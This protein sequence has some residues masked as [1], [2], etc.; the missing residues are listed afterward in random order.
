VLTNTKER[1][2]AA[3]MGEKQFDSPTAQLWVAHR[4]IDTLG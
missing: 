4:Q 2:V 3:E 1:K